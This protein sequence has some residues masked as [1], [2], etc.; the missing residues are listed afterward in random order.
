MS[1]QVGNEEKKKKSKVLEGPVPLPC[2][3][4]SWVECSVSGLSEDTA[5]EACRWVGVR[6]QRAQV[7]EN[8]LV[9]SLGGTVS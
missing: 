6:L 3:Q 2:S 1:F 8:R 7:R 4:G 5:E 9:L